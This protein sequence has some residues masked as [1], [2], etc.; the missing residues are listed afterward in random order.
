[1]PL[2]QRKQAL[3]QLV[4]HG[5]GK[6]QYS[7]HFEGSAPA[8]FRAVEKVGLKSIISK[9]ADSSYRSGQANTWL[10]AEYFEEADF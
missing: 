10:K 8:I 5:L 7:E 3:R 9:R 4:E 2:L 6:I 1:M